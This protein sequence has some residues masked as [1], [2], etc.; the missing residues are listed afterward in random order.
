MWADDEVSDDASVAPY[1][2]HVTLKQAVDIAFEG[3][4]AMWF[5]ACDN[6]GFA[7]GPV[8]F[9]K[10]WVDKCK[11]FA[12]ELSAAAA[13]DDFAVV[14]G[15]GSGAVKS[16]TL[17][18]SI[19]VPFVQRLFAGECSRRAVAAGKELLRYQ[20]LLYMAKNVELGFGPVCSVQDPE[21]DD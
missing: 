16:H 15:G 5:A 7:G 18:S 2:V 1:D 17:P 3:N 8:I 21:M 6:T 19:A 10:A 4:N 12:A 14:G 11:A 9:R 13:H 20:D